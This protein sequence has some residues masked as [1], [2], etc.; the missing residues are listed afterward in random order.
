MPSA[1]TLSVIVPAF[2]VA[3]Y[4]DEALQSLF[5]QS[6]PADEIIVIDD[7]ST[8]DTVECIAHYRRDNR[9]RF[10]KQNN[11][12]LGPTRN[13]GANLATGDYLYF[14]DSD[15]V[16]DEHFVRRIKERI[17][18]VAV[19]LDVILFSGES[20]CEATTNIEKI[21]YKRN[22]DCMCEPGARVLSTL[23][24][25]A[26]LISSACLYVV[27]RAYWVNN[28]FTFPAT[29]HEDDYVIIDL[30]LNADSVS[31]LS[32]VLF[33][34]RL[35]PSS[36]MTAPSTQAHLEGRELNLRHALYLLRHYRAEPPETR[37]LLE[38]WCRIRCSLYLKVSESL[39]ARIDYWLVVRAL[40]AT[41]H[42]RLA[43]AV[44]RVLIRRLSLRANIFL[45]KK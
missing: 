12:G 6:E 26:G 32:E 7:G 30:I 13:R 24:S 10:F 16:L 5:S 41:R 37:A 42:R 39:D 2:D 22:I 21:Y 15:D 29:L 18:H 31:V 20:F 8:D 27:R 28:N 14:F 3:E 4:I 23:G 33:F 38:H 35:R 19:P 9:L 44:R 45:K 40:F 34:R 1:P 11:R 43:R 25:Q 36:I 17:K